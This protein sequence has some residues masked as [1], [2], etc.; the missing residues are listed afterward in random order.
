MHR[1]LFFALLLLLCPGLS[2][3]QP[4]PTRTEALKRVLADAERI[5]TVSLYLTAEQRHTVEQASGGA[6]TS[7]LCTFYVGYRQGRR[8]GV[9]A[10]ESAPVRTQPATLLVVLNPDLSVRRVEVLAF[11]EPNE[12]SPSPRW[13][14]QF[15]GRSAQTGLRLGDDLQGITGA[16][17]STQAVLRQVRRTTALAA[18][19]PQ[20][21]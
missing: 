14:A 1:L 7:S 4:G 8:I 13:L 20:E 10:I 5:E 16:T 12:Y 2:R 18:L 11:S 3:A 19:L 21:P 15:A 6:G 17:L 9:A